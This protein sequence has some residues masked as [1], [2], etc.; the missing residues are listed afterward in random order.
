MCCVR[1]GSAMQAA[2]HMAIHISPETDA[3][4]TQ[5]RNRSSDTR[6]GTIRVRV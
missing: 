3:T 5:R 6:R 1:D 2:N 4:K